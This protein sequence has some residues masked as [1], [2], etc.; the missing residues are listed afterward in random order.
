MLGAKGV[1]NEP[2]NGDAALA[3]TLLVGR[4][5]CG[6]A[7]LV[8]VDTLATW[9]AAP[10]P[11][12]SDDESTLVGLPARCANGL[13]KRCES[14]E[15]IPPATPARDEPP[16][17][18]ASKLAGGAGIRAGVVV[19]EFDETNG[20]GA[21]SDES[22]TNGFPEPVS[23]IN[24][25]MPS[26][27]TGAQGEKAR[28]MATTTTQRDMSITPIKNVKPDKPLARLACAGANRHGQSGNE[29]VWP[30]GPL[31][32]RRISSAPRGFPFKLV[33]N[34]LSERIDPVFETRPWKLI[35]KKC[36]LRTK[37]DFSVQ[38]ASF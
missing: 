36:K 21:A 37:G 3:P 1:C 16:E 12:R 2:L 32:R 31:T 25:L 22:E 30:T 27:T 13:A 4:A 33:A 17:A 7:V 34:W 15:T 9:P 23:G 29:P 10:D 6:I 14:D 38:I 8:I 26:A 5:N 20:F 28:T 24:R 19:G 18:G 35:V 11:K